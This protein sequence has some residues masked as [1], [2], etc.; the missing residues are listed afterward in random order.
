MTE[1]ESYTCEAC[2]KEFDTEEA[3]ER[4]MREVGLVD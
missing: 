2:D 3:L 4:H 1:E